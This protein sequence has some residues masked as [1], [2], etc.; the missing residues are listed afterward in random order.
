MR[1]IDADA[2]REGFMDMVYEQLADD[3]DNIRANTIIDYFDSMEPAY[4]VDKVVAQLEE[5]REEAKQ[6][7]VDGMLTDIIEIVKRG[8][9]NR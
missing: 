6:F 4:D 1:L 2:E 5:L 3:P 8:G 9:V 7:G